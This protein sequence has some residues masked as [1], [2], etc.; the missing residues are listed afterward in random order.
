MWPGPKGRKGGEKW[1]GNSFGGQ[2]TPGDPVFY[3]LGVTVTVNLG[4]GTWGRQ[5]RGQRAGVGG[6]VV[7]IIV[8][9]LCRPL[10]VT[11]G[12][13]VRAR[14]GHSGFLFGVGAAHLLPGTG[15]D[16][17]RACVCFCFYA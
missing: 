6:N 2:G 11:A 7:F 15:T 4:V 10:R 5:G 3:H 17:P 16:Q 13:E 12:E 1:T 8:V 14:P 9:R